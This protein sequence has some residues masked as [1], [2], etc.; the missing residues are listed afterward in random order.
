LKIGG[1]RKSGPQQLLVTLMHVGTGL[2]WSWRRGPATASERGLLLEQLHV[3]PAGVLLLMDAGFTGYDFLS[4]LRQAGHEV[5]VR[6]GANLTLLKKLKWAV[7]ER[8]DLVY[9]WPEAAQGKKCPPLVLRRI[10]VIDGR[11]RRMCLLTSVEEAQMSVGE[12]VELYRQRWGIEVLYR[13]LKQTL[14]RRKMLSDAPHHA[15]VELDWTMAG[16]WMLCLLLWEQ[17]GEQVPVT[18][19]VAEALRLVRQAMAGRGDRRG[20]FAAQWG[21]LT[22]DAYRRRRSKAARHWP[23]KKKESPCG[24]PHMRMATAAEVRR[25]KR[26]AH[27]KMAA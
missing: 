3:L 22:V 23:H 14:G 7:E 8:G 26:L 9:L 20:N 17:R 16:Y 12:A 11:N 27:L 13:G 2:P 6:A 18:C 1:K 5:L 19:G 21:R 24:I 10:V 4:T 15:Q 25:A